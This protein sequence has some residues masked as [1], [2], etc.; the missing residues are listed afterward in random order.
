VF[1]FLS[2]STFLIYCCSFFSFWI[3][4]SNK[5]FFEQ[6]LLGGL[7]VTCSSIYLFHPKCDNSF[8]FG[9]PDILKL[10][11]TDFLSLPFHTVSFSE[12][13]SNLEILHST[14]SITHYGPLSSDLTSF[15]TLSFVT[16]FPLIIQSF[17]HQPIPLI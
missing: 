7:S 12:D 8:H 2:V 14:P 16:L 13:P 9:Q 5:L 6:H 4:E 17:K 1:Y 11:C 15:K 3:Q 10:D